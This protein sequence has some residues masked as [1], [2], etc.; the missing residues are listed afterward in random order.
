MT[1]HPRRRSTIVVADDDPDLRVAAEIS[2]R[3]H[4]RVVRVLDALAASGVTSEIQHTLSQVTSE[5]AEL[6]EAKRRDFIVLVTRVALETLR[7]RGVSE[8]ILGDLCVLSVENWSVIVERQSGDDVDRIIRQIRDAWPSAPTRLKNRVGSEQLRDAR[9]KRKWVSGLLRLASAGGLFVFDGAKF[10]IA[11]PA[12]TFLFA[13][14]M[15]GLVIFS[16]GMDDV[17]HGRA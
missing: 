17:V 9:R 4:E 11:T 1:K 10:A 8:D 13:S 5:L 2:Q 16:Q 14:F 15:T 3:Q 7:R 12:T 6:P